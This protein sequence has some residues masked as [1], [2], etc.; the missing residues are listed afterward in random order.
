MLQFSSE[1]GGFCRLPVTEWDI[2]CGRPFFDPTGVAWWSIW[3]R[4]WREGYEWLLD[5][6]LSFFFFPL[7][8]WDS[9]YILFDT[10]VPLLVRL[11]PFFLSFFFWRGLMESR[12]HY[13]TIMFWLCEPFGRL[14][15]G[16]GG[17]D[18]DYHKFLLLNETYVLGNVRPELVFFVYSCWS[19]LSVLFLFST[20]DIHA[21]IYLTFFFLRGFFI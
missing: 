1:S 14:V 9:I 15:V 7:S 21:F 8:C 10:I 2:C 18:T 19:S 5:P 20:T 6:F 13:I 12:F 4:W 11:T 17:S 3:R 16:W